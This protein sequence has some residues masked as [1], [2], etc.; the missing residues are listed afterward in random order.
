MINTFLS[1]EF[2]HSSIIIMKDNQ[3]VIKITY[4]FENRKKIRYIDIRH[5][6]IRQ[7]VDKEKFNF[8]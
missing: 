6:F 8:Q 4:N 5:H 2:I 1:E 3:S 7:F